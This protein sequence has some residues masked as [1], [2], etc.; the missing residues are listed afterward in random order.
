MVIQRESGYLAPGRWGPGG[1]QL[2][3]FCV[4]AQVGGLLGL[5]DV[6]HPDVN[7]GK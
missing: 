5:L 7:G 6:H 1:V 2:I 3:P 4:V